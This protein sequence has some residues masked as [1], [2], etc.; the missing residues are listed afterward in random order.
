MPFTP[1]C[2]RPSEEHI[3]IPSIIGNNKS[4][5]FQASCNW[6]NLSNF[7]RPFGCFVLYLLSNS[8][9]RLA[10]VG[11][12]LNLKGSLSAVLQLT[13]IIDYS[14]NSESNIHCSPPHRPIC[15]VMLQG[16]RTSLLMDYSCTGMLRFSSVKMNGGGQGGKTLLGAL[17]SCLWLLGGKSSQHASSTLFDLSQEFPPLPALFPHSGSNN[18]GNVVMEE[19]QDVGKRYGSSSQL[20]WWRQMVR[21]QSYY[22][23]RSKTYS[24][25]SSQRNNSIGLKLNQPIERHGVSHWRGLTEIGQLGPCNP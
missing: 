21:M 1:P 7:V 5:A 10:I 13:F 17:H 9:L 18:F 24:D 19:C 20:I 25:W 11:S 16:F 22:N 3:C 8:L 23:P 2:P 14:Y 6:S 12:E 15:Q 4:L